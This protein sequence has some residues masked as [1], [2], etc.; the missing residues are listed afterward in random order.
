MCDEGMEL[1]RSQTLKLKMNWKLGFAS[2]ERKTE[3][4]C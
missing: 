4:R 1:D 3:V 2:K